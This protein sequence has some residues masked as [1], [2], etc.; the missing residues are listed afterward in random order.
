M[1]FN[2]ARQSLGNRGCGWYSDML[3]VSRMLHL[4]LH[5][6][7]TVRFARDPVGLKYNPTNRGEMA[8]LGV[9]SRLPGHTCNAE[10][11]SAYSVNL[12]C[13]LGEV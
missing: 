5:Q 2:P 12:L 9:S 4:V 1:A 10:I 3:G 11:T 6:H 13:L 8:T 7:R